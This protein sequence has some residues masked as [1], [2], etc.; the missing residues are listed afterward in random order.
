MNIIKKSDIVESSQSTA[1]FETC[2]DIQTI[3]EELNR[4]QIEM[5]KHD[6]DLKGERARVRYWAIRWVMGWK[7]GVPKCTVR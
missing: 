1:G 4:L 7:D 2:Q 5:D 3:M 6:G